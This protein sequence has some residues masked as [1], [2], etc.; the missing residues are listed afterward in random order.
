M[1][2][3]LIKMVRSADEAHGGP[4]TVDVHPDE[5]ANYATGGFVVAEDA[6]PTIP[7]K[8]TELIARI[9][10][11]ATAAEVATLLGSDT[12]KT[13]L[14]AAAAR[15]AELANAGESK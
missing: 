9:M 8:A 12:R 6:I 7:T 5:V 11:A 3:E 1:F 15:N 4:Q 13:V 14:D 10:A 2:I